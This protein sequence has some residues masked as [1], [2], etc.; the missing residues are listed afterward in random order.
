MAHPVDPELEP[1]FRPFRVKTLEL[2]NRIV[3]APM[4]RG[5]SPGGVRVRTSPPTIGDAL[6]TTSA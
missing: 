1:L 3:M 5:F 4:T 2:A 6:R